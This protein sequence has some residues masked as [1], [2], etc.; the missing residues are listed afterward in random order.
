[1]SSF[2]IRQAARL[3]AGP[4]APALAE[5]LASEAAKRI[6]SPAAR[7]RERR[8][9][10]IWLSGPF[11]QAQPVAYARIW[12]RV[13][14]GGKRLAA[15][16]DADLDALAAVWA[17]FQSAGADAGEWFAQLAE[18]EP[19]HFDELLDAV[20]PKRP[21]AEDVARDVGRRAGRQ[22]RGLLRKYRQRS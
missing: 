5:K 17:E 15:E 19:Q 7:E 12:A 4:A 20:R 9:L 6:D 1:M 10:L 14:R 8:R 11:R 3:I 13:D 18:S 16:R 21:Q 2:L 22:A